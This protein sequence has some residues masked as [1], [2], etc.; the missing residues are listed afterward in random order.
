MWSKAKVAAGAMAVAMS[1]IVPAS[2]HGTVTIGSNLGRPPTLGLGC[3]ATCT[4]APASLPAA[5]LASGGLTSPVNGRVVT[6]RIRMGSNSG[7]DAFRVIRRASDGSA[8]G[9]AT[10]ASVT[11]PTSATTPYSAD[12]PIAIGD[13]IGIDA[14]ASGSGFVMVTGTTATIDRWSPALL[15]GGS[16]QPKVG[17]SPYEL[18]LSADIEPTSTLSSVSAKAKKGKIRV[19]LDTPNPGVLVAGGGKVKQQ[20]V[21]VP[22]P[23]PLSLVLKLKKGAASAKKVKLALNFTPTGGNSA[24]QSLKVKLKK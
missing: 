24:S 14:G 15:D 20:T 18:A 21:Q 17:T 16:P 2:A 5:S 19:S 6:W 9:A 4:F 8:T 22:G 11:P 13:T 3:V 7:P 12:L 1:L 23:G 10:T